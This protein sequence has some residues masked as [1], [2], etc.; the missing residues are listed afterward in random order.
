MARGAAYLALALAKG[1]GRLRCSH[2]SLP[3]ADA[4]FLCALHY[5][6][7]LGGHRCVAAECA[8]VVQITEVCLRTKVYGGYHSGR[9][10][11]LPENVREN[12]YITLPRDL[13]AG[14]MFQPGRT[15]PEMHA[16]A[17]TYQLRESTVGNGKYLSCVA[18]PPRFIRS[19]TV[20]PVPS[21]G[22]T[23]NL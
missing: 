21:A 13:P 7:P 5:H 8:P 22:I 14:E 1:C 15:N 18:N 11:V 19:V 6:A 10:V 23:I 17:L 12:D 9:V 20:P 2:P 3:A 16:N 4:G